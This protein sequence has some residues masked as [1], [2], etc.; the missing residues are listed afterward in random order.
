MEC[1]EFGFAVKAGSGHNLDLSLGISQPSSSQ[2]GN[3]NLGDFQSVRWSFEGE[4]MPAL[5]RCEEKDL[6]GYDLAVAAANSLYL[7]F[8]MKIPVG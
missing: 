3:G 8:Y 4:A 1:N 2:K 7:E 5:K 6:F